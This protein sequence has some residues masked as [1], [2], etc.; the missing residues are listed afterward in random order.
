MA[1][2]YSKK[3]LF[4][5]SLL[6]YIAAIL[7]FPK[8]IWLKKQSEKE[9]KRIL[10]VEPF[11]M[12]DVLS[13][14]VM[15]DPILS[16]FPDAQIY[17]LT[18]NGNDDIYASDKRITKTFTAPIPW[19]KVSGQKKGT[20]NEWKQLLKTCC[21]VAKLNPSIGLDTRSE[22]RSQI[23]MLVCNCKERIGFKN[24]LNTNIN[25]QGFL[26]TAIIDK[27]KAMHRYHMNRLLV[28][29]S[30][31][32]DMPTLSFPTFKPNVNAESY[33]TNKKRVLIHIGARWEFRQWSTDKWIELIEKLKQHQD[34]Y[35]SITAGENEKQTLD[36]ILTQTSIDGN[37]SDLEV[38]IKEI[39]STDLLIC[40]DSGPMHL[41]Q[42][43]N[44]P[45]LAL[46]GP[47]DFD[48]W[49]P[50]GTHDD[51]CFNKL[52]CSPCLQY[53]CE[54]PE[55]PCMSYITV[56]DVYNKAIKNLCLGD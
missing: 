2:T 15:L 55:K 12:G 43:L 40:L 22:I 5:N 16:K 11:G 20:F 46:F 8:M 32:I 19:S 38:L 26:L 25:V 48:L 39:K 3:T 44:I 45:V 29:K 1:L 31:K 23:L 18:K 9:Q 4:L 34:L 14:S 28:E 54:K 27:P 30:L 33:D 13:L 53:V 42:T 41:A 37:I 49:H 17:L 50:L 21:E 51:T 35:I 36:S 7:F 24:Y 6:E 52:A 47:G 56:D 10:L